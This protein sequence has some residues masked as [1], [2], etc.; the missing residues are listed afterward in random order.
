MFGPLFYTTLIVAIPAGIVAVFLRAAPL[1]SEWHDVKA[2]V[3]LLRSTDPALREQSARLL[4]QHRSAISLPILLDAA[5]DPSSDVRAT[6]CKVLAERCSDPEM[7]LPVLVAATRDRSDEVREAA[8]RGLGRITTSGWFSRRISGT[9]A[10]IEWSLREDS[11]RATRGLLNDQSAAIRAAAANALGGFG[12]DTESIAALTAALGD[13]DRAVR[14]VAA[15]TL[16]RIDGSS[17]ALAGQTLL[18]LVAEPDVVADRR[19][20]LEFLSGMNS[21]VHDRAVSALSGLLCHDETAVVSD[22]IACLEADGPAA[23]A[24]LPALNHLLQ[25]DDSRLRAGA[26]MA[27]VAI[28][29][30]QSPR[31]LD[32]LLRIVGDISLEYDTRENAVAFIRG[33]DPAALTKA[34]PD[35]IRQLESSS[36]QIRLHAAALL[37]TIVGDTRAEIPSGTKRP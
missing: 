20:V 25:S 1:F 29:G 17:N 8:C 23:R 12:R 26:A 37:T 15:R 30:Q 2:L 27:I 32:L 33:A 28:E 10:A 19:A 14:F 35:L 24:A 22:V 7:V 18:K 11:I 36:P 13:A 5:H 34:T 3:E 31:A 9:R 16:V 6:A 4:G 21:Q